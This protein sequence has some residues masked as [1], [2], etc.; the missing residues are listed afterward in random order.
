MQLSPDFTEHL[1]REALREAVRGAA[2]GEVPVGAV[3]ALNGSIIARAHNTTERDNHV[4][5]HAEVHAIKEA[6]R[7]L[8]G[9]RLDQCVL[10]VTLEP[11]TMCIGAV[12]LARIPVVVVGAGDSRQGAVGSLYD[13]SQDPR[14]GSP[15]RVIHNVLRS[16][17]ETV[18]QEFFRARRA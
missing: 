12:R 10:A 2:V 6:G 1:M 17:C 3:I 15:P 4:I 8:G 16:E 5:A 18:M 14:L 13:L 11:C 9:W 7:V